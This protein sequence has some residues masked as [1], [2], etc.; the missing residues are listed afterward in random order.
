MRS[1]AGRASSCPLDAGW[2]PAALQPHVLLVQ[3]IS[4][5]RAN[6]FE[7]GSFKSIAIPGSSS[8]TVG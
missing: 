3:G 2:V 7:R 4:V 5:L 8:P 1:S 6:A